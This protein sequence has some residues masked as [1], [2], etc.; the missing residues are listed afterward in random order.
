MINIFNHLRISVET[1]PET[2]ITFYGTLGYVM[3][4]IMGLLAGLGTM[5]LIK[6][7]YDK[8]MPLK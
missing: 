4:C 7:I 2:S 6:I 3:F 8:I 5:F 1:L